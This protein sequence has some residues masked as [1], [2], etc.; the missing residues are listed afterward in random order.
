MLE[1]LREFMIC[2]LTFPDRGFDIDRIKGRP[3]PVTSVT[4]G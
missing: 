2:N 4:V 3:N 1:K